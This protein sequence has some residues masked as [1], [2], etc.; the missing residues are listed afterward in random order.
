MDDLLLMAL[1]LP[2]YPGILGLYVMHWKTTRK[3]TCLMT[4]HLGKHPEDSCV[5]QTAVGE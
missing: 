2:I 3:M 1:V 5:V 4:L